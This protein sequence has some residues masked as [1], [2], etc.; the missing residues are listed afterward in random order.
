MAEKKAPKRYLVVERGMVAAGIKLVP[1]TY[2][3]GTDVSEK[4]ARLV[5]LLGKGHYTERKPRSAAAGEGAAT[6][7][8]QA[9][10]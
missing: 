7:H 6:Q 4:D 5:V 10:A 1:N 9:D 8:A 3:V 2:A